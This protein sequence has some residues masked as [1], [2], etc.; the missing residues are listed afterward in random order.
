MSTK[1]EKSKKS[2]HKKLVWF[3]SAGIVILILLVFVIQMIIMSYITGPLTSTSIPNGV[4]TSMTTTRLLAMGGCW[5]PCYDA[6]FNSG[7]SGNNIENDCKGDWIFAATYDPSNPSKFIVGAFAKKGIFTRSYLTS[8]CPNLYSQT[9]IPG[10]FENNVYWY[11]GYCSNGYYT[12]GLSSATPIKLSS[13]YQYANCP[14]S[15]NVDS[16]SWGY[17]AGCAGTQSGTYG[18]DWTSNYKRTIYS[19]TC[20]LLVPSY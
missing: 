18:G 16:T 3:I 7:F 6:A 9:S 1:T 5:K 4:Q 10:Y 8:S 14:S 11:G 20:N 2:N 15:S 17:S 12:F 13:N 19:N